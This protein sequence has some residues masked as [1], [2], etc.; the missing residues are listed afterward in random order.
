[1][2]RLLVILTVVVCVARA[3]ATHKY[4]VIDLS[5][6]KNSSKYD[7][8]YLDAMPRDGWSE[9][10]KTT[11][12][13]LRRIN[14]GVFES[15]HYGVSSLTRPYYIGVFEVTQKQWELVM[16]DRPSWFSNNDHYSMRP[17]DSIMYADIRGGRIGSRW[18]S[19]SN[20][21]EDCFIARLRKRTKLA[22]DLPTVTQWEYACRAGTDTDY[23]D[24]SNYTSYE[25]GNVIMGKLGRYFGNK[26]SGYH[27]DCDTRSGTALVGSYEANQW[28]LYDMHGNV[29]EWCLD[30]DPYHSQDSIEDNEG[31]VRYDYGGLQNGVYRTVCGGTWLSEAYECMSDHWEPQG[32]DRGSLVYSFHDTYGYAQYGCRIVV[33]IQD[34]ISVGDGEV[35][36]WFDGCGGAPTPF[37]VSRMIGSAFGDLPGISKIGFVFLGWFTEKDAGVQITSASVVPTV[38]EGV[39]LYAHWRSYDRAKK[40]CVVDLSGGEN[41]EQ[42]PI[43]YLSDVPQ[44]GWTTEYKTTKLVLRMIDPR[45]FQV[46][47]FG[48]AAWE[49]E[50]VSDVILT[51]PFYVGVFE[52]TQRQWELVMGTRPSY[53]ANS[54]CYMMRPVESVSY[55][56][57]RGSDLGS[58]WPQ[59]NGVDENSFMGRIRKKTGLCFDL[60]TSVQWEYACRA[61]TKTDFNNGYNYA[62][63][64]GI[65]GRGWEEI[66]ERYEPPMPGRG[67]MGDLTEGTAAVGSYASN[68]WGL[69]DMHGNVCEWCLDW[70]GEDIGSNVNP[71]GSATG[72]KRVSRGGSWMDREMNCRSDVVFSYLPTRADERIGF[73]LA[74]TSYDPYREVSVRTITFDANGGECNVSEMQR[75]EGAPY[76]AL[77]IPTRTGYVFDGWWTQ[78][79]GGSCIVQSCVVSTDVKIYAHWLKAITITFDANGGVSSETSITVSAGSLVGELPFATMDGCEFNGWWTSSIG[80]ERVDEFYIVGDQAITV[81]AHW[82]SQSPGA[83]IVARESFE[84]T[85]NCQDRFG[86][87]RY[88]C[89]FPGNSDSFVRIQGKVI[90]SNS[91]T[92]SIWVKP[93]SDVINIPEEKDYGYDGMNGRFPFLLQAENLGDGGSAGLGLVVGRN[94]ILLVEHASSHIPVVLAAPYDCSQDWHQVVVT[95]EENAGPCLYVDGSFVKQGVATCKMKYWTSNAK[96]GTGDHGSYAGSSDDFVVYGRALTSAEVAQ[97]FKQELIQKR[98]LVKFDSMGGDCSVSQKEIERGG[99]LSELPMAVREGYVFLGWF[100]AVEGGTRLLPDTI[101]TEDVTYY[102]HW[103]KVEIEEPKSVFH[104]DASD[105]STMEIVT[106]SGKNYVVRWNDASGGG[107]YATAG[108]I[109]PMLKTVNDKQIVD[110]GGLRME[111]YG[112]E[113]YGAWMR[114]SESDRSVREVFIVCCDNPEGNVYRQFVLTSDV[115][116]WTYD[117]HRSLNLQCVQGLFDEECASDRVK[118][119]LIQVDGTTVP[120]DYALPEGLHVLHIRTT[121][122]VTAN[123]FAKDRTCRYG[124]LMIAEVIVYNEPLD[125]ETADK[126]QQQLIDKWLAHVQDSGLVAWYKFDGSLNDESG[127][128][129]DMQGT[130]DGYAIGCDSIGQALSFSGGT[131]VSPENV[132]EIES[133]FTIS[134]WL[135]SEVDIAVVSERSSGIQTNGKMVLTPGHGAIEGAGVGFAYGKNGVAIYEHGSSYLPVVLMYNAA[136]GTGWNFVTI[137]VADNAA[138]KLYLNGKFVKQGVQGDRNYRCVK[139]GKNAA[140][141]GGEFYGNRFY[142]NVDDFRIYNRALSESEIEA[143]CNG[144]SDWQPVDVILPKE[145]SGGAEIT[146]PAQWVT[147]SLPRQYGEDRKMQFVKMYGS[148]YGTALLKK[149]GKV[150]CAGNELYV[151]QDY[152]AGTDPTDSNSLFRAFIDIVNGCPQIRWEPNLNGTDKNRIYTVFGKYELNDEQWH[153]PTNGRSRFFKVS[154]E[155]P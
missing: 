80:G 70:A 69:Y 134:G 52:I 30:W 33:N 113:N 126:I 39:T 151:W 42:Y 57:V 97:I 51:S 140:S 74:I 18:P 3:F 78:A 16:G 54:S 91:F 109:R 92:F 67:Y 118:N 21:D 9:E 23:S 68:R 121:G 129:Y 145:V 144:E 103:R 41:A 46:G 45:S 58:K 35:A 50:Y 44:G 87:N 138:P 25:A 17:V 130:I 31:F 141:I 28:G 72:E 149:S 123:T 59:N 84:G 116:D 5:S 124:G 114:W 143:L 49:S 48:R 88:A 128:G 155:M 85:G 73:R 10:Y 4:M 2:K 14:A 19:D 75:N 22:I 147:E 112:S 1:M 108:S 27:P 95:I 98:C 150:D 101:I 53:C 107:I 122:N 148:D 136:I 82:I 38:D 94:A 133:S 146:I 96:I 47:N 137:T 36:V 105:L 90:V 29:S 32:A 135:K 76:G 77:P 89:S 81:Y 34:E 15:K 152:V 13:V 37:P 62:D 125:D 139:L 40:Y 120:Y 99:A 93:E 119:G 111:N 61:G 26:G 60:P 71:A 11:K 64:R 12:I 154:V 106:E 24:G 20:V 7:V 115:S 55:E 83:S 86:R 65:D 6:G 102:A 66:S 43:S 117:F 127:N 79:E 56:M 153:S 132:I 100:T 142:G 104:V 110:F 8:S 131:S 63:G